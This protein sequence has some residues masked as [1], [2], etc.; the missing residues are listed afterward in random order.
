MLWRFIEAWMQDNASSHSPDP[1][2]DYCPDP[3]NNGTSLLWCRRPNCA[4]F[5]SWVPKIGR[6]ALSVFGQSMQ[7][8]L[9]PKLQASSHSAAR[10]EVINLREIRLGTADQT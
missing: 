1:L 6:R 4:V 5:E 10:R 2:C 3:D 8:E 9:P 7:R